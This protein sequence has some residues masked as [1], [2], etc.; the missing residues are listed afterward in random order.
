MRCA[1][2]VTSHW[3]AEKAELRTGGTD[4]SNARG[5]VGRGLCGRGFELPGHHN[6]PVLGGIQPDLPE[7]GVGRIVVKAAGGLFGIELDHHVHA[8]GLPL[9]RLGLKVRRRNAR[10]PERRELSLPCCRRSVY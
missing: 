3:Q 6:R 5:G 2:E 7:R 8:V 9:Q 10:P 1:D 4:I